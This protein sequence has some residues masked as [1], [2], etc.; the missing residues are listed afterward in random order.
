MMDE[1]MEG[2]NPDRHALNPKDNLAWSVA[3][4]AVLPMAEGLFEAATELTHFRNR[5]IGITTLQG[6]DASN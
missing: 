4:A 5:A 6:I 2:T 3:L 1:T